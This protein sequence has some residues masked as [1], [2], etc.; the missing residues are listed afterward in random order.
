MRS[1]DCEVNW[2]NLETIGLMSFAKHDRVSKYKFLV[3][4]LEI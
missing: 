4:T 2:V 3:F 1:Y